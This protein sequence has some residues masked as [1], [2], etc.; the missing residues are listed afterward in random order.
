M[1]ADLC[2][3]FHSVALYPE[4]IQT[5]AEKQWLNDSVLSFWLEVLTH[6][7]KLVAVTFVPPALVFLIRFES[8]KCASN[9]G[10][11]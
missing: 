7:E 4:D 3:S 11:P 9:E 8:G 5:I 6:D 2:V 1:A 10:G